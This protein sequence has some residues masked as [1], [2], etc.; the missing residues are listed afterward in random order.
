MIGYAS[1]GTLTTT[2]VLVL[3]FQSLSVDDRFLRVDDC[4]HLGESLYRV[5]RPL[6]SGLQC[7]HSAG[8]IVVDLLLRS[9]IIWLIRCLWNRVTVREA[10]GATL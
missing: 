10:I 8:R 6:L 4:L 9:V 5:S 2:G 1:L 3:D 7:H